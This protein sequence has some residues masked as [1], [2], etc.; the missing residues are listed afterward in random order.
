MLIGNIWLTIKVGEITKI[1]LKI[2]KQLFMLGQLKI[3]LQN[4]ENN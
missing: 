3:W 1:I 4:I 2:K